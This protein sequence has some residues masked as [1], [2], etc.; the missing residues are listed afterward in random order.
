MMRILFVTMSLVLFFYTGVEAQEALPQINIVSVPSMI[1]RVNG[2]QISY[3]ALQGTQFVIRAEDA[4]G[5]AHILVK[6]DEGEF[7]PYTKPI[8]L[9]S[10]KHIIVAK[11]QN[12]T[13]LWSNEYKINVLIKDRHT[14]MII[15]LCGI[16]FLI[17]AHLAG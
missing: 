8:T 5:I 4:A 12:T 17:V 15:G 2:D 1:P 16:F 13:G 7:E 10:G 11:A 9:S 3:K 14:G 6:I